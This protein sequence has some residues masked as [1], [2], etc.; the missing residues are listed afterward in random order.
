MAENVV[1]TGGW[2]FLTN[3]GHALIC[4]ARRPDAVMR[5]V[6]AEIGITERSL[7]NIV[8][9]LE[10]SGALTRDRE[11]RRNR[12]TIHQDQPLRH[13]VESHCTVGELITMVEKLSGRNPATGKSKSR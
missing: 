13:P 4:L 1:Q 5:E 12:Y 8:S 10:A 7:H 6:A 9:D 11:G 2:T 3:H